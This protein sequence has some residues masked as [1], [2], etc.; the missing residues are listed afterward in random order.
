MLFTLY[1]LMDFN[2]ALQWESNVNITRLVIS[3]LYMYKIGYPVN[4][5]KLYSFF[6]NWEK[7]ISNY[8]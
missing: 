7:L 1:Y 8:S 2:Y 4:L 5:F 3:V 6:V